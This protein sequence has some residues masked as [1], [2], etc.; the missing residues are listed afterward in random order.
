MDDPSR[1]VPTRDPDATEP[2]QATSG[3][4]YRA[5]AAVLGCLYLDP[6]EGWHSTDW[7][8]LDRLA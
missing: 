2:R 1:A 4:L 6:E 5:R 8:D 3:W 7:M